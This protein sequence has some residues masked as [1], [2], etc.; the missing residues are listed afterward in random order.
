MEEMK[1]ENEQVEEVKKIPVE[2]SIPLETQIIESS[3][4]DDDD[5][6]SSEGLLTGAKY[7]SPDTADKFVDTKDGKVIDK[8]NLTPFQI[9]K[10]I[11][12]QNNHEIKDPAEGCKKCYGRGYEG[13]DSETQMPIPCRCLFRGKSEKEREMD[14]M[15]DSKN[16]QGKIVRTQKRRMKA[17]LLKQYRL[18]RK[19]MGNVL[20]NKKNDEEVQDQTP[21]QRTEYVNNI[22]KVYSEVKSIKKA[23][24]KLSITQTELKKVLKESR[25]KS[26]TSV[27]ERIEK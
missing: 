15:Y 2:D 7:E 23:S 18:Q 14:L 5:Y 25:S 3:N 19:I 8:E 17:F 6:D 26:E 12:K 11:A 27:V 1:K 16:N 20:R 21:E 4:D 24:A 13:M 9:I 10:S 22:L